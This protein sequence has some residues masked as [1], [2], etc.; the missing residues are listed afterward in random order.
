MKAIFILWAI[1]TSYLIG[2]SIGERIAW[3]CSAD[4]YVLG[5]L[6]GLMFMLMSILVMS[7]YL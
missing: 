1:N 4:S 6:V 2:D 5:F 7:R 3:Y